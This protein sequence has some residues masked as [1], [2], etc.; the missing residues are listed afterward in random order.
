FACPLQTAA[1]G[2]VAPFHSLCEVGSRRAWRRGRGLL[3]DDGK[4]RLAPGM[5][6]D[7]PSPPIF[8]AFRKVT[9]YGDPDLVA[10]E[11]ERV[12]VGDGPRGLAGLV[13][14]RERQLRS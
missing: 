3:K 7:F 6:R 13:G 1:Q 11:C 4:I 10:G 9:D 12:R 5:A 8:L 2:L 14:N